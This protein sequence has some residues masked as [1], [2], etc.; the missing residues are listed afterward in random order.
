MECNNTNNRTKV[1]KLALYTVAGTIAVPL[2]A[3]LFV[4][5]IYLPLMGLTIPFVTAAFLE[6]RVEALG[7]AG[8]A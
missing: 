3:A 8:A 1:N 4:P 5:G 6:S 2:I 7:C